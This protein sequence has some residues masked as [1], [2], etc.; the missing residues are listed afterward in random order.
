M[1]IFVHFEAGITA[2]TLLVV[3]KMHGVQKLCNN[4]KLVSVGLQKYKEST[5]LKLSPMP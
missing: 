5:E 4:R 3:F 1:P 2:R